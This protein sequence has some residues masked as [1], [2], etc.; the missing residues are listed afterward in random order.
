MS[1][2]EINFKKDDYVSQSELA[3]YRKNNCPR[4]CPILGHSKFAPVVDHDHQTG[5]IRGVI[6]S[7]GNVLIGK[8]E[9]FYKSRCSNG[10]WD[11]PVVLRAIAEYL[12]LDQGRL[13]PVGVRQLTKRF[14]RMSKDKQ[15]TLLQISGVISEDIAECKNSTERTKLYRKSI[16]K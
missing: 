5:R 16:I 9:N 7:E 6:S 11:L 14:S 4:N 10:D 15:I 12:E 8:I 2:K 3:A 1:K 13:H